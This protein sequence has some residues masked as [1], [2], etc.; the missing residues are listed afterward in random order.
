MSAREQARAALYAAAELQD[1]NNGDLAAIADV[2]AQLEDALRALLDERP[3]ILDLE[4][5][6]HRA[7]IT[8]DTARG[9]QKR[10]TRN[11]AANNP[12]PGDL[13]APDVT[14]GQTPGWYA[15]TID[16]WLTSRPRAGRAYAE[17]GDEILA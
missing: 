1:A 8:V 2:A 9:Y 12:R 6:A 5:I 17:R 14:L 13:P 10:A 7:D 4:A 3:E 16:A 11:R 15:Q